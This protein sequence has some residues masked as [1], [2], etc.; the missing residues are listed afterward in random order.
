MSE[1]H[2]PPFKRDN[3]MLAYFFLTVML[4][5]NMKHQQLKAVLLHCRKKHKDFLPAAG[6]QNYFPY[7]L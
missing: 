5:E 6:V 7:N 2:E 4:Q 3:E 1:Q